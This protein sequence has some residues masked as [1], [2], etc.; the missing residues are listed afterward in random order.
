MYAMQDDKI[1]SW[2][3]WIDVG[4]T[5]TDCI[6]RAPDGYLHTAKILSSGIIKG[7]I[8]KSINKITIVDKSKIGMR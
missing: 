4:C 3:F 1:S 5:F 2:E 7:S 8:D 6:G